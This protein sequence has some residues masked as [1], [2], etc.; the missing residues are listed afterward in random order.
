[1]KGISNTFLQKEALP[2]LDDWSPDMITPYSGSDRKEG[3][4]SPDGTRYLVKYA[5]AHTRLNDLDTSY[6][7]NVI[8]EYMSSHILGIAGFEVHHTFI[9]TR[10]GNLLVACENFTTGH[11]HLIEFGQYMRKHYDSGDIGRVPDIRQI[12]HVL[13]CDPVLHDYADELWASYWERFVGDALVGNFDRHMGNWG[14]LTDTQAERIYASSIYD[15][16]STLFHALSEK[17]M[18]E[19]ILPSEKEI[20]K[21]TLL[22]PKAALTV[23]GNKVSYLDLL[24]S[25]YEP[26]LT[27][28]VTKTVPVILE[29]MPGIR[30]F[31]D[32]QGFLSDTRKIFYKTMLNTRAEAILKPAYEC[33]VSGKFNADAR[34]R[35]ENG[36][37]YTENDFE[38]KYNEM[39]AA[40]KGD[41]SSL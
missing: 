9:G 25:G 3:L 2:S 33:C 26:A 34:D 8:S 11:Q 17:A 20:M 31:I 16:G 1:M 21:R 32:D 35:L 29:Q 6:V 19:D 14:Y 5:E 23:N 36:I 40:K 30:K 38:Q 7:N 41:S 10:G 15:N 22:F 39:Y 13:H 28:A 37:D 4:I 27:Q 18:R 24:S 12:D